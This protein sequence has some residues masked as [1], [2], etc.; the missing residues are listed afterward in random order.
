MHVGK[1]LIGIIRLHRKEIGTLV[2]IILLDTRNNTIRRTLLTSAKVN[3]N[4]NYAF[5]GCISQFCID[6]KEFTNKI[7]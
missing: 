2:N 6:L 1:N 3:M 7:K 4:Q 5:I